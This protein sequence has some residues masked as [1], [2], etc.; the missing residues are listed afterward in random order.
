MRDTIRTIAA[1]AMIG[2][3]AAGLLAVPS[4]LPQARADDEPARAILRTAD[5]I[6]PPH[7]IDGSQFLKRDADGITEP[8]VQSEV[9]EEV[10]VRKIGYGRTE[11]VRIVTT[12]TGTY[13][14]DGLAS[15]HIRYPGIHPSRGYVAAEPFLALWDG[16]R[17]VA[18]GTAGADSFAETPPL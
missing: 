4:V 18:I 15:P 16:G 8:W 7:R 6:L 10:T 17:W 1:G 9:L 3:L 2:A 5:E 12:A 14:S 11:F 13:S